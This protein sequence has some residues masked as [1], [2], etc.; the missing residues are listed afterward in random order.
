[1]FVITCPVTG[2]TELVSTSAIRAVENHSTHIALSVACPCGR[3]HLHRTGRRWAESLAA[4]ARRAD[5][6][7]P[8]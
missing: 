2:R 7:L 1:M 3:T 6:L 4:T 5:E 8:A